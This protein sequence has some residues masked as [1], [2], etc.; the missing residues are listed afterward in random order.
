[1]VTVNKVPQ[2]AQEQIDHVT[3]LVG[4]TKISVASSITTFVSPTC[5]NLTRLARKPLACLVITGVA[6]A[7]HCEEIG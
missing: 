1:M 4:P 3:T 7:F 5:L 2:T 6:Y